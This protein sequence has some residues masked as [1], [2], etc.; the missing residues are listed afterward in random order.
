MVVQIQHSGEG[1]IYAELIQDRSFEGMAWVTG[2]LHSEEPHL[3]L[4]AEHFQG[5]Q[6]C[7][8]TKREL[9]RNKGM[10][11]LRAEV[12]GP[13]GAELRQ[14]QVIVHLICL[15]SRLS[16]PWLSLIVSILQHCTAYVQHISCSA[17]C[18]M[19]VILFVQHALCSM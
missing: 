2:F 13:E 18:C 4:Q 8:A 12:Q 11:Q 6:D 19:G 17:A 14:R 1:G 10:S 9:S 5:Q 15:Q 16:R 7:P 3:A